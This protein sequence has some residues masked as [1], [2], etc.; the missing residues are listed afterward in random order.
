MPASVTLPTTTLTSWIDPLTKEVKLASGSGV[1]PGLCLWVDRELMIVNTLPDANLS[2]R[3]KRGWN[4]TAPSEHSSSA[5]V[6]IGRPDQFYT[7]DPVGAP[8]S[9]IEVSPY[10]NTFNGKVFYAQ[11]D[12]LPD[13]LT[14]RW[15]QEVTSTYGTASRGILTQT[16]APTSST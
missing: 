14:V 8:P 13:H 4:G 1:V 16:S 10:I 12:A 2:V 3:V 9:I 6:T 7:T 11:G 5:T 15:W